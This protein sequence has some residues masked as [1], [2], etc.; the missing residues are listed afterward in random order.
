MKSN[1]DYERL[2]ATCKCHLAQQDVSQAKAW[3]DTVRRKFN[4]EQLR[5]PGFDLVCVSK[6]CQITYSLS[7][8][9]SILLL[10]VKRPMK[11]SKVS[12]E[13]ELSVN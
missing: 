2:V 13:V 4:P 7:Q 12:I 3:P 8:F 1:K 11:F 10:A 6:L 5:S 9:S